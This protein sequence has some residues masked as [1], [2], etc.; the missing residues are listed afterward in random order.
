QEEACRCIDELV[1]ALDHYLPLPE[2][3]VDKP[4][5]MSVESV[6][7][8]E[9]R[10]TV[11]TGRIE[12]GRI[13]PG[14]EVEVVG[15]TRERRRTVVTSNEK[16]HRILDEGVAGDNVG[17]LLRGVKREE[18]ERGQVLARPSSIEPHTTF[19]ASVYVLSRDEGGRHTPFFAG[20]R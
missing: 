3:L 14:E 2:R 12:R 8:I 6:H 20:Y 9:G 17:V 19:E 13:R 5:L 10:G 11:A 4:F 18:L 16:F 1:D 7:Q 15:L